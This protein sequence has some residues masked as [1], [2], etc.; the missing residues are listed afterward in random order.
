MI[1]LMSFYQGKRIL[2]T[3]AA[4]FIASNLVDALIFNGAEVVGVDN[5]ITGRKENIKHLNKNPNFTFK[6]ADVINQP[7]SYI[8]DSN[9]D[10]VFHLA[11]PASP[12]GYQK[13]PVETYLVNSLGTHQLLQY[14]LSNHPTT[15]FVYT[16]TSEAYGDPLEHPQKETYWGNVNPNGPRSMYDEG[17]RLGETICGV[18]ARDFGM[19]VRIVRI[20]NTYGP[21]MDIHDGRVLPEYFLEVLRNGSI[22][23]HGDGSQTRSFCYV[24]DLV[25]GLLKMMEADNLSNETV[26]LGNPQEITMKQLAELVQQISKNNNPFRHSTP[27]PEDPKR[28]QP[29]IAKAKS[30]LDWGPKTDL[31]TGLQK[32]F[33]YFKSQVS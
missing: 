32:T 26:N 19:D 15:R 13:H 18:H 8:H 24:D 9:F 6:E 10:C 4:G 7:D 28:R 20:F 22:N 17:K 2:V 5:F 33:E 23:I 25:T 21:R 27:R 29:D 30:L 11:S 16:S 1:K 3:G 12:V 31:K 14:F